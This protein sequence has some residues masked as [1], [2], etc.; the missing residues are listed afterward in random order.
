MM[1]IPQPDVGILLLVLERMIEAMSHSAGTI[2]RTPSV[3]SL[4]ARDLN[5]LIEQFLSWSRT[6]LD[7]H[8]TVD[9]YAS[10]LAWFTSWW[11]EVGP[12]QEWRLKQRD[13]ELFERHLRGVI[14]KRTK[15]KLSWH[16]RN[17][18]MRRLREMFHWAFEKSHTD[19]DY[20]EWVPR[21]DGGAPKRRA[22][23]MLALMQLLSAAGN[24]ANASRDRAMLAMMM[25][26]G[27]RRVEIVNL[28]VEDVT[29][30]ADGSGYA[31]VI[32]KS[33]KAN[34]SGERDAAFDA[35]TGQLI[36]VHMDSV[37]YER[38]ALFRT[39]KGTR[40]NGQ[41]VYRATKKLIEAAGLEEEIQ[42]CHDLRRAFATFVQ[43]NRKGTDGADRL[44]RQL[45]HKSFT[46]T[47]EYA[48]LDVEDLRVD[49]ISPLRFMPP[50]VLD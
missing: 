24:S 25:G 36:R 9:S 3:P 17:D 21:A 45:G 8:A 10:N 31:K 28:N 35:A 34:E 1:A 11:E 44:R 40:M 23:T 30:E 47:A 2:H 13:L 4:N 37:E 41:A 5:W 32:G 42:A 29:I 43:R 27:L 18:V 15:Q 26:M 48:L 50:S 33:T 38:G 12:A 20:A 7:N 6:Q 22:A 49:F 16:S 39:S 46:Q 14:S 19:R